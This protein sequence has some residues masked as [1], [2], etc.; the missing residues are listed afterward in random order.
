LCASTHYTLWLRAPPRAH[1]SPLKRKA[2]EWLALTPNLYIEPLSRPVNST[3]VHALRA[4]RRHI[5]KKMRTGYTIE[6]HHTT[7]AAAARTLADHATGLTS[8]NQHRMAHM[9]HFV[10]RYLLGYRD[11]AHAVDDQQY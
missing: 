9:G 5:S 11:L 7:R 4:L 8:L 10:P 1:I 6:F 2:L 3:P